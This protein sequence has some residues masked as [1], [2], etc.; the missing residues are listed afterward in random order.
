[1]CLYAN[2]ELALGD[3]RLLVLNFLS[4]KASSDL[5][6]RSNLNEQRQGRHAQIP[7]AESFK[8]LSL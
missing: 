7:S 8:R 6:K 5:D 1:M 3:A 4:C 2:T